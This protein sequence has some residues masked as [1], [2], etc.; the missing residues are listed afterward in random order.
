MTSKRGSEMAEKEREITPEERQ[1]RYWLNVERFTV[2]RE[3][4]RIYNNRGDGISTGEGEDLD[5]NERARPGL[6]WSCAHR[7]K[8]TTLLDGTKT[9][10]GLRRIVGPI[11]EANPVTECTD[12]WN[13]TYLALSTL[14]EMFDPR[15]MIRVD[16]QK[17]KVQEQLDKGYL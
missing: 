3:A 7:R 9:W 5:D 1:R 16:R 15:T 14:L 2:Q 12:Y 4:T 10:C 17:D 6:C 13:R 11:D 8:L